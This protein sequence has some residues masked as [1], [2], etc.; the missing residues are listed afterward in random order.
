MALH[1][2]PLE[3]DDQD[4]IILDAR[5]GDLESLKDIFT[6]VVDPTLLVSCR[7]SSSKSTPLHMA[8]ANGHA[9]VLKFLLSL[10]KDGRKDWVNAQNETGNT[11]LHWASLNGQEACVEL[12]CDEF[13]AD[14]FIRN[15]FDHDAIFE[16]E[17]SG[18][19][20]IETFFLKKYDVEPETE[21]A[22]VDQ[23]ATSASVQIKEGTEIEQVTKEATEALRQETEKLNIEGDLGN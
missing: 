18:H 7:D 3:Q 12:L 5:A 13:D 19:E 8:A 17:R 2:D 20:A 16:A 15:N 14:P 1:R 4:A 22:G 11:A 10:V 23:E 6:N 21:N 9:E